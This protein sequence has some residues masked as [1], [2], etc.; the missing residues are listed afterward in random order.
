MKAIALSLLTLATAAAGLLAEIPDRPEKLSFPALTYEPPK[1]ADYRVQL[2]A[3]PVAYIATD[4][5]LPLVTISVMV[6]CGSYLE[7]D[8]KEGLAEFTQQHVI[9]MAKA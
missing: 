7:P 5:A 6:R 1:P 8:G 2:K 4:R 9:N 3:G